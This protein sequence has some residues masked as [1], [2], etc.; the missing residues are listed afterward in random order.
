VCVGVLGL[1]KTDMNILREVA[2]LTKEIFLILEQED[3]GYAWHGE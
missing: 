3:K 2:W 1:S